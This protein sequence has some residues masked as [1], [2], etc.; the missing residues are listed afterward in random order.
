MKRIVLATFGSLGDLHPYVALS[1]QL[2]ARGYRPLIVTSDVHRDAV[3][4]A[5][6]EFAPMRPNAGHIGDA[7]ELVRRLFHPRKGPEH[8]IRELV[9]PHVRGAYEDLNRACAG[10]DL[11]VTHPLAFGGRL[12]AEKR[13]LPW[14]STVLS[15]LSLMSSVDPPL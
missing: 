12:V 15:P 2:K 14:R 7:A 6:I 3:E 13:G 11:I 1:L 8:L 10:A 4:R 9:M 5:G